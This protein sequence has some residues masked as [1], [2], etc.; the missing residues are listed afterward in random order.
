MEL[1]WEDG[2]T[3]T[4]RAKEGLAVISANRE[5]LRSL[6]NHLNALAEEAPGCHLHLDAG[7]SLEE[8]SAEL[9]LEKTE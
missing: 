5:G 4:V 2:F 6:A 1:N 3:I 8:G 7:N 9:I